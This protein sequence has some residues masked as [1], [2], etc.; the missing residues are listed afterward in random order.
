MSTHDNDN[1]SP[2]RAAGG[3]EKIDWA[4]GWEDGSLTAADIYAAVDAM[5]EEEQLAE[6][7][8]FVRAAAEHDPL[9]NPE[10]LA[11]AGFGLG[12]LPKGEEVHLRCY[13]AMIRARDRRV[14]LGEPCGAVVHKDGTLTPCD[15]IKCYEFDGLVCPEHMMTCG[16]DPCFVCAACGEYHAYCRCGRLD[17]HIDSQRMLFME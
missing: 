13:V 10:Q 6:A 1:H 5:T 2:C 16:Y 14:S 9:A 17:E 12:D 7:E 15:Q 4:K 3:T 11:E 8:A